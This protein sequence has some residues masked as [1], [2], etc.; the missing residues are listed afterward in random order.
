MAEASPKFSVWTRLFGAVLIFCAIELLVFHSGI[1]ASILEPS[2]AAGSV[3]TMVRNEGLR[4]VTSL[5]EVAAIGDSRMGALRVKIAD[6]WAPE[7]GYRFANISVPGTTPRC[8]YYMLREVDPQRDRYAAVVLPTNEYEDDDWENLA[9]HKLDI[10]YLTPLLRITDAHDFTLSFP[11]WK[12]RWEAFEGSVLKGWTY[13]RDFQE[14]VADPAKR[15]RDVS[16]TREDRGRMSYNY[17]FPTTNVEGLSIDFRSGTVE[18]PP[19]STP[20]QQRV[21][22][23]QLLHG[24]GPPSGLR[25]RYREEWFGRIFDYYRG[26]RTKL[27]FI[28]MPRAPIVRPPSPY[29]QTASIREFGARGEAIVTD[30]HYFDELERPDW[31]VDPMHLNRVGAERFTIL[32]TKLVRRVLGPLAS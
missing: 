13:R 22:R 23:E 5:N 12:D 24:Y 10:Y 20:D 7:V 16:W 3:M 11:N 26:S 14:L 18:Y 27:I 29:P 17:E 2:S 6:Q 1:Y 30:E 9:D 19:G 8:W 31:F 15:W 21:I 4:S 28:R 32:L 25:K